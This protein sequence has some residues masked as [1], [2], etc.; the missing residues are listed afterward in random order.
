MARACVGLLMDCLHYLAHNPSSSTSGGNG[1]SSSANKQTTHPQYGHSS[2]APTGSA[3]Q[4]VK[5]AK[6]VGGVRSGAGA[7]EGVVA[8][9]EEVLWKKLHKGL[10]AQNWT[11]KFK[12]GLFMVSCIQV[13]YM[14]VCTN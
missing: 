3:S 14:V 12:A 13:Q 6:E 1:D 8:V 7:V 10:T 5:E 2:S 4:E 11:A 9:E